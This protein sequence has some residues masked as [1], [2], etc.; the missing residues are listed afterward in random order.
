MINS[1]LLARVT[2]PVQLLSP[3]PA[4]VAATLPTDSVEIDLNDGSIEKILTAADFDE[5]GRT[6]LKFIMP[7]EAVGSV[8]HRIYVYS[9]D[10]FL[11]QQ[12]EWKVIIQ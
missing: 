12:W 11:G 5:V 8:C 4:F 6:T 3:L 2:D 9:G 10:E 7:F 1:N